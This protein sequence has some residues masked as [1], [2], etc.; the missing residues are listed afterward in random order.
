[1][2]QHDVGQPG[3]SNVGLV[4][5]GPSTALRP[6]VQAASTWLRVRVA[7]L[8]VALLGVFSVLSIE[9]ATAWLP[10]RSDVVWGVTYSPRFA[11]SLGFDP[12]ELYIDIL[13][14][15]GVRHIRF[16]IYW[17]EVESSRGNYDFTAA[18]WY[19]SEALERNAEVVVVVGYKQPRW[20]EC[21]PP[22]WA[23]DL[24]IDL[25]RERI[26]SLI[27]AEVTFAARYPNVVM[28]QVENEPFR[29]FGA[30][31]VGLLTAEFLAEEMQLVSRLDARPTLMTDSGELSTWLPAMQLSREYFGTVIYRQLHFP[32]LGFWQ[33]PLPPWIYSARNQLD[34][35]IL[36][37]D[38]QTI[39][40]ELQ[41]EAWF[42]PSALV[43]VP[44]A[45]QQREFP[46]ELLLVS[47]VEYGRR[48]GFP[49]IYLW[50]VEWWSWMEAQGYPE[51]VEQARTIFR[52]AAVAERADMP[53][54]SDQR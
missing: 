37:Q 42:Q 14:D 52:P 3:I 54:A 22:P 25:L 17:D 13:D 16:P 2:M 40:I 38:G 20:P 1:M 8:A 30:Y 24:P 10:A 43:D 12:Q 11:R 47:N 29:Q 18:D 49:R 7:V 50:G 5:A 4:V 28:W 35:T 39:L 32:M 44:P 45:V 48:T 53:T 19:L 23:A 15:I 46:A 6:C 26:L 33:H 9:L 36:Q 27:E 21:Y 34:R 41:A 51:Y 31:R